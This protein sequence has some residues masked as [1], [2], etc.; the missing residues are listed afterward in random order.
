M[1]DRTLGCL[2]SQQQVPDLVMYNARWHR[3]GGQLSPPQDRAKSPHHGSIVQS[4]SV[5]SILTQV[6]WRAKVARSIG[7]S[8]HCAP[9]ERSRARHCPALP[10][11]RDVSQGRGGQGAA[12]QPRSKSAPWPRTQRA[13]HTKGISVKAHM[14]FDAEHTAEP[15]HLMMEQAWLFSATTSHW[16]EDTSR[17]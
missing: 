6:S 7:I 15:A 12:P 11:L 16:H 3:A 9:W 4:Y 8:Q 2:A 13:E 17:Q 14:R 1:A 5:G 10:A